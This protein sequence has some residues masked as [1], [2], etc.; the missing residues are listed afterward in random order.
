[1]QLVIVIGVGAIVPRTPTPFAKAGQA[2]ILVLVLHEYVLAAVDYPIARVIATL[3][4]TIVWLV[5]APSRIELARAEQPTSSRR[6]CAALIGPSAVRPVWS[7]TASVGL[8]ARVAP[9][10]H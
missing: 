5:E 9:N 3:A 6:Q 8:L 7:T 2:A 1:M 4:D 10:R